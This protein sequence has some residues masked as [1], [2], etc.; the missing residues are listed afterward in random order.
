MP[1]SIVI[2][3]TACR[4]CTNCLKSCPTEAIR[5]IN[6]SITILNEL[7]IDCG[8]C[9]RVCGRSALCLDDDDWETI[10]VHGS[11]NALPDPT[12]FAQFGSFFYPDNA[13]ELLVHHGINIIIDD[14]ENA[15]DLSAYATARIIEDTPREHLPLI[16]VYCP[17]V[18][19]LIQLEYPELISR[20]LPT[21]NP[22]D[23]CADM[24]RKKTQSYAPLTLFTP[25]PSKVTLVRDPTEKRPSTIQH[26]VSIQKVVH[27]LRAAG[28][29]APTDDSADEAIKRRF[30]GWAMIGGESRHISRFGR[31]HFTTLSVSGLRNT[32]DLLRQIE[33]GL[34]QGVDFVECRTCD[35]GCFGGVAVLES[36]FLSHVKNR[37]IVSGWKLPEGIEERLEPIYND[38]KIWKRSSPI[39]AKQ[40]LPLSDDLSIAVAKMKRMEAIYGDMPHIDCGACGRPSCRA[41]AEDVVREQ[42]DMSDCIFK[43]REGI[44]SLAGQIVRLAEHQPKPTQKNI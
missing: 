3:H 36:R 28:I 6:G 5:V 38:T 41:L 35:F 22:I 39:P 21:E 44:A 29:K 42:G 20:L 23:I 18:V 37:N 27:A 43:L 1:H 10:H 15:F 26:I 33:L 2:S 16:S 25:C 8:E 40:R 4:G 13:R 30:A 9:L 7:C 11:V 24:W 31:R 12:F 14:M 17:S 32:M 34:L 19:S